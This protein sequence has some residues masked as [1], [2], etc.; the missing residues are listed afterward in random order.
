MGFNPQYTIT[1]HLLNLL[2][3]I[4]S[5][6]TKI[7]MSVVSVAWMPRLAK[8]ALSKTARSSTAIEGN[9]LTLKEVEILADG[10][11]LPQ[12]KPRHIQEVLNYFAALKHISGHKDKKEITED[13]VLS[14]HS[15][16]GKDNALERGPVG[17]YRTYKVHVGNYTPPT[18]KEVPCL[19][20]ELFGWLNGKGQTLPTVFTSSVLH[21]QFE[22]IHPFGDGN[23]RTGR[24]LSTWEMYRRKFDTHHIF[25]VDEILLENR[26]KYY[27]A[28][29]DVR[30][31]EGNLTGW[32]EFMGEVIELAL[33]RTW[34]RIESIRV[35]YK[36]KKPITLTP[37]QEKL[38]SLLQNNSM[39]ISDIQSELK[40]SKPGAH[41]LL[42]PLIKNGL[43]KRVGG[44][45]TGKYVLT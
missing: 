15:I 12:A 32:L 10:G 43:V 44:H 35:L 3:S 18:S 20:S 16:V 5:L 25:S 41:F 37:K 22:H 9:P 19:M 38:L 17:E 23:G 24:I 8:E 14:L 39:G 11:K 33:E 21:Y 36:M 4:A 1:S 2:E 31:Q 29:D 27:A 42:K 13:D 28:L 7:E 6:K 26:Q 34:G 30:R 45:K 40:V